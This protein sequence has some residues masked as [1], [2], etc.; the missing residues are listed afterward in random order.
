MQELLGLYRDAWKTAG[1]AGK[2]RVM[3]AFH[4]FCWPDA[5]NAREIVHEAMQIYLQNFT[6]AASDWSST[7]SSDYAGY[8]KVVSGIK[9]QTVESLALSGS[10]LIGPPAH[11]REQIEGVR[12]TAGHCR[13][14]RGRR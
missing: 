5:D 13:S 10:L 6:D 8:D 9:R 1:H 2:P 14:G 4:M 12:E 7:T 3:L 11:I